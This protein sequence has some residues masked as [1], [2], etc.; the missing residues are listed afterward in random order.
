M[1]TPK[2]IAKNFDTKTIK[3]AIDLIEKKAVSD[4]LDLSKIP[5]DVLDMVIELRE[6]ENA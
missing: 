1:I 2:D 6:K 3:G 4:K 5:D